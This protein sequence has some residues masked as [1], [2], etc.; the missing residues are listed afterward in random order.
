MKSQI[1][2]NILLFLTTLIWGCTF[3]AQ[4]V[5]MEHI[6]PFEYQAV[7]SIIGA[8]VLL[9]VIFILDFK[10]KRSGDWQPM[11]IETRK[12]LVFGGIVC[13][14]CLCVASC[15]QQVGIALGTSAGKAGFI[16]AMYILFV[17]IIGLFLG[18]RV[19]PHFWLCLALAVAGLYL[20][21]ITGADKGVTVGDFM[22][23]MCAIAFAFQILAIDR[24]A[25]RV[26][27][28][29]LSCIQFFVSGVFSAI[30]MFIFEGFNPDKIV[31]ALGPILFAGVLSCGVAYT[32]Q[33]V[34]QKYTEPTVGSLIMS[35]ESF[36]AVVAESVILWVIPSGRE[37]LGCL[38]MLAAILLSQMQIGG[39]KKKAKT[40]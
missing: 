28:L 26:D 7:R 38:L 11:P 6:G 20:L 14:F 1:K 18:K 37:I 24:F 16:T 31:A 21:C 27:C 19:A 3:V 40:A 25:P 33:T 17:P 39:K 32:L 4:D 9:P 30:P 36:F 35:F 10:K 8:V 23:L 5:A 12:E 29:K 13:G 15:F 34:G 22:T 2:G